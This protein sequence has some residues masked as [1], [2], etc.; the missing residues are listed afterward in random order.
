MNAS[1]AGYAFFIFGSASLAAAIACLGWAHAL[2]GLGFIGATTAIFLALLSF[3]KFAALRRHAA[4]IRAIPMPIPLCESI[5]APIAP[6]RR[7]AQ[8]A[9]DAELESRLAAL[10]AA[11]RQ[12]EKAPAPVRAPDPNVEVVEETP[13]EADLAQLFEQLQAPPPQPQLQPQLQPRS[14]PEP[15]PSQATPVGMR[16]MSELRAEIA[17][18]RE[19]ARTRHAGGS[20]GPGDQFARTEFSG[21]PG[22]PAPADQPEAFP[23]TQFSGL[24]GPSAE[25]ASAFT[26]TEYLV[27]VELRR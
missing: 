16:Q 17:R 1:R 6:T 12:A 3:M 8:V 7:D 25:E 5:R 11:A 4:A 9:Q 24:G 22:E 18:L 13:L 14:V 27:P 21:L 15:A 19:G 23:R 26:K 20:T 2:G 10:R